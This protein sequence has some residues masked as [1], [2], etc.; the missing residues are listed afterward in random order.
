MRD[1]RG[2]VKLQGVDVN[3]LKYLGSNV[4]SDGVWQKSKERVQSGWSRWKR[5]PKLI[6]GRKVS[7]RTKGISHKTVVRPDRLYGMEMETLPMIK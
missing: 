6:C 2:A 7:A 5:V 3:Q 1:D 4:Q